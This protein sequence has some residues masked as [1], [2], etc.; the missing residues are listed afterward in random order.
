[1]KTTKQWIKL[2]TDADGLNAREIPAHFTP[3]NYTPTQIAA[4][5]TDKISA[6]LKGLDAAL[7]SAGGG[8][9]DIAETSFS[10][11]NNQSAAA[12]VTSLA[13]ANAN[14]RSFEALV[15]VYV[16]ATASLYESFKLYGVQRGADW[17]LSSSSVGDASGIVFSITTSGQ[18]QYTSGNSAGFTATTIKFRAICTS[19]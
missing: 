10:A 19:V 15:S 1:M 12:N 5:G 11:A 6:H 14:V 2:T 8:A 9:Y 4:E 7:S 17:M 3:S 16:N 13:F 18:V